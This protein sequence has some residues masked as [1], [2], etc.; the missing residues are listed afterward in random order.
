MVQDF[1]VI[2]KITFNKMLEDFARFVERVEILSEKY[3]AKE[4][5]E[6]LDTESVC[7]ILNIKPKTLS[8]Y[9]KS[10]KIVFYQIKRKILYQS[11]DVQKL[12][13]DNSFNSSPTK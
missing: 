10:G 6:W 8:A 5:Q 2:D 3:R 11:K 4:M 12:L 1:I 9:R 13:G 7:A